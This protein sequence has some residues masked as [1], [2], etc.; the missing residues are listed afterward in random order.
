MAKEKGATEED[1]P[2]TPD[3]EP[4]TQEPETEKSTNGDGE[5]SD[6]E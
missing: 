4:T 3:T 5:E 6:D 1:T 2:N